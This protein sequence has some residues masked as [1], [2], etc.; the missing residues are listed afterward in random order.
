MSRGLGDVYKR[1][2]DQAEQLQ[3]VVL[4]HVAQL[5]GLVEVAPAAFD[6]DLL[7]H[8]DLH[9]GDVVLVPLGLEQAVGEAQGDQVLHRLLAQV[10]VDPVNAAFREESGDRLVDLAGRLQVMPDGLLQHHPGT[11]G[12]TG[13]GEVL[14][15]AAEHRGRRGEVGDQ[16]QFVI[17]RLAQADIGLRVEEVHA[18]VVEAFAETLPDHVVPLLRRHCQAQALLQRR[19]VFGGSAFVTGQGQDAGIAVQQVLTIELVERREQL[20]QGE[21][22]QR[23]EQR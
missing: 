16:R 11:F 7:G 9:V 1:H 18:Q 14:A 17:H 8:G 23:T 20:A 22:A 12:E 5:P 3:Q 21:I 15:D 4:H 13:G 10:M 19:Q 6:A 2:G